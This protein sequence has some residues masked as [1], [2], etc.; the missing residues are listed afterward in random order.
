MAASHVQ[1][2]PDSTGK[3]VDADAL[4]STEGGTPTVYR[5]NVVIADPV[6]YAN[7]ANVNSTGALKMAGEVPATGTLTNVNASATSVTLLASNTSRKQAIFFNDSS[8]NLYLGYTSSAVSVTSYSIRIPGGAYYE[9]P[10]PVY[11]GQ[12]NGIWDAVIGT[13]RITEM[14]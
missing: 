8:A 9:A 2:Q 3:D 5:Q 4:T 11:T 1:V 6:T 13:V 10:W 7:K 12:I 14:T